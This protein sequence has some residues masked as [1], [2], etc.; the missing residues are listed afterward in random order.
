MREFAALTGVTVRALRHYDRL[1]LL[2]PRRA[3]NRYRIYV[4]SDRFR[5]EQVLALKGVGVPLS[6]IGSLLAADAGQLADVFAGQR[7]VLEAR[8]RRLEE[9][10]RLL[11]DA[12]SGLRTNGVS[13]V[14][15]RRL[16]E[17]TGM[18]EEAADWRAAFAKLQEIAAARRSEWSAAQKQAMGVEWGRLVAEVHRSLTDDPAGAHGRQLAGRWVT[19]LR[20]IYGPDVPLSLFVTAGRHVAEWHADTRTP[21]FGR[22]PGFAFLA[23]ALDAHT[24]LTHK[25]ASH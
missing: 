3:A 21:E 6:R 15:W 2:R 13:T 25:P 18:E 12:E 19:M 10:V 14:P 4:D 7:R 17:V 20:R 11:R 16:I 8:M 1:G 23:E 5:L 22:W 9:T 24:A